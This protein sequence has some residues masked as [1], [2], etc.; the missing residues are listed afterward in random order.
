[1]FGPFRTLLALYR[2]SYWVFI[3]ATVGENTLKYALTVGTSICAIYPLH[4][5]GPCARIQLEYQR[6]Q[7]HTPLPESPNN[8]QA[9]S[10]FV[11]PEVNLTTIRINLDGA[12]SQVG[13]SALPNMTEVKTYLVRTSTEAYGVSNSLQNLRAGANNVLDE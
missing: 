9:P 8:I 5:L 4:K 11:H 1:M 2:F 6:H 12:I 7:C 13:S 10:A 3:V